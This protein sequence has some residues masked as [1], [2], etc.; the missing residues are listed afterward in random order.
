MPRHARRRGHPAEGQILVIFALGLIAMLGGVALVIEGGN[1]YQNQRSVQNAS[2]AAAEAGAAVISR[3][4]A[5]VTKSDTDVASAMSANALFNS[6][7]VAGYYTDWQGN[8]LDAT[9]TIVAE[10][11]AVV[12]G[13]SPSGAI[14][15]NAQGVHANGSRAFGTTIGHVIGFN[16][17]VASAEAT[18][19][20]GRPVGGLFL[21]V[22]FPVN[23]TDCS[24]NG[25]LGAPMTDWDVSQPDPPNHPDGTEYIVPLCKTGSGSFMV[26]DLDG[27]KNNCEDEVL[28][29]KFKQ[30]DSFP[31]DVASDNGNNCAKQMADAVNTRHGEVVLVPICDNNECNTD[32]GSK[33]T[34]HIT[35]VAAFWIDYMEYSN[36]KTN[37]LCQTH[38]NSDGE[39]LVTISGNG[40]SSCI[41]GYFVRFITNGPVGPGDIGNA[42]AIAIQLIE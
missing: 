19:V 35:G 5:G 32:G 39:T 23:I 20:T 8:P 33:A 42:S 10:G 13:S 40:S 34:Y 30:F 24:G 7:S 22:V 28:H 12:V 16:S 38:T 15:P 31:T 11:S 14:P 2:D 29:P 41:A 37:S 9:G 18:A 21:P 4:L 27:V 25:S 6:I 36:N 17:F 26:L 3:S 1:A